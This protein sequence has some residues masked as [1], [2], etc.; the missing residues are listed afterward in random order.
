M[1][2]ISRSGG[3]FRY[4]NTVVRSYLFGI[5]IT[6]LLTLVAL[7][8]VLIYFDPNSVGVTGIVLLFLSL[9]IALISWLVLAGYAV[10]TRFAQTAEMAFKVALR[11]GITAGLFTAGLILLKTLDF[12]NW[13]N[14]VMLAVAVLLLEFRFKT[15][16]E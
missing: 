16:V 11:Q 3:F 8:L 6:A 10:R 12:L 2:L 4:T 5:S 9:T 13:W 1:F 15:K 7:S 14:A